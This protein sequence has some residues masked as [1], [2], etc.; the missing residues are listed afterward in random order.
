MSIFTE[1]NLKHLIAIED[2]TMY[3][4]SNDTYKMKIKIMYVQNLKHLEIHFSTT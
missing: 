1:A 2:D 4:L 3:I